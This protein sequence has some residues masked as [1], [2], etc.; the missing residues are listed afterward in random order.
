M[1]GSDQQLFQNAFWF[2]ANSDP[3]LANSYDL[4]HADDIGKW[5]KHL[6]PLL[7]EVLGNLKKKGDLSKHMHLVPRWPNLKHFISV[8]TLEFSDGQGFLDVLKL[9]PTSS[10]FVHCI[11]AHANFRMLAGLHAITELQIQRIKGYLESYG[12]WCEKL[13]DLYGKDFNFPKQHAPAHLGYDIVNKG[14]TN[15]YSTRVGEGFQQEAQQAYIQTNGKKVEG[16]MIT[17][18]ENQEAIACIRMTVDAYDIATKEV[19]AETDMMKNQK[20]PPL[21]L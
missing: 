9:L 1:S 18:D 11:Q 20:K 6:W 8:T 12:Y 15:N 17:I 2:I 13:S 19:A 10:P 3:Y 14:A 5:G 16:R 4:L 7:L 21:L